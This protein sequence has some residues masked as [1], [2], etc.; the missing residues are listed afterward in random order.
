[1]FKHHA[2]RNTDTKKQRW[3][4][5]KSSVLNLEKWLTSDFHTLTLGTN[6]QEP[7]EW[8]HG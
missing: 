5:F 6:T 8:A 3:I 2:W 7:T 1:M 4:H